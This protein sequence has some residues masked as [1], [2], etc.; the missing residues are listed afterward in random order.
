MIIK[1]NYK[2]I[3]ELLAKERF[4]EIKDLTDEINHDY[5]T[6]YFTNNTARE[7][8]HDFNNGIELFSIQS[9]EMKLKEK[10]SAEC[11]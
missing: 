9:G 8:F 10:R 3:L 1:D 6:H 7:W 5:L 2:E 4:Y 11:I